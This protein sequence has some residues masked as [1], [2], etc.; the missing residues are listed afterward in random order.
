MQMEN[1]MFMEFVQQNN[2]FYNNIQRKS[3]V[4]ANKWEDKESTPFYFQ[5]P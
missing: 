1:Y 4:H 2:K 3:I 5:S